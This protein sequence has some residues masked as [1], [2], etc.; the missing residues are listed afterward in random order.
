MGNNGDSR[1]LLSVQIDAGVSRFSNQ[2]N[3]FDKWFYPNTTYYRID[4]QTNVSTQPEMIEICP[5]TYSLLCESNTSCVMVVGVIG[6]TP[7]VSSNFRIIAQ[8]QTN[9]LYS[10]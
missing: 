9:K 6:Q 10:K 3:T 5:Q 4:S 7:N 2:T 1:I 8:N